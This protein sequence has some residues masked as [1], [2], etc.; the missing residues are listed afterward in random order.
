MNDEFRIQRSAFS[1]WS[2]LCQETFAHRRR[3]Y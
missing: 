3:G 2:E 1:I